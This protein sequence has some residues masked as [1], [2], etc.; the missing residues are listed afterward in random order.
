MDSMDKEKTIKFPVVGSWV[1]STV[2][3]LEPCLHYKLRSGLG[4]VS[5]SLIVW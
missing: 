4:Q 2:V 1:H 5:P 3:L